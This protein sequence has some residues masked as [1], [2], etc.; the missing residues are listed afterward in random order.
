MDKD[1]DENMDENIDEN[2]DE[3]MEENMVE[4]E[5]VDDH[6]NMA[7]DV[8]VAEDGTNKDNVLPGEIIVTPMEIAPTPVHNVLHQDPTTT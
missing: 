1:M 6:T 5:D 2:M 8:D 7:E 3:D 4:A